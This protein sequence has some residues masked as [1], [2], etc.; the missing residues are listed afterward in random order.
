M[1]QGNLFAAQPRPASL[2]GGLDS[3]AE[4]R[5]RIDELAQRVE[6]YRASYYAGN[7]EISDAAYDALEDELRALDPT[8]PVL[9]RVGSSALVTEWEKARH[10]IPMGSLNKVVNEDELRAWVAR[11]EELLGKEPHAP[12]ASDLFVAEKLDG[13]SIEV[14]YKDGKLVDAITRGDGEWGERITA[15]VAR[16][17]GVPARIRE[18]GHLSVRGEIIL[19]LS[20]M[21]AHFPGVTSPRNMAAGLS[22]RFDGQ[23]AERC[24]VMFYDVAEHAEIPTCRRRFEWLREL[25]FATPR[26]AH[27]TLDDVIDLYRKYGSELRG[28]LDYEIDGLVVYV[29]SLNL[30]T[31]LG[32]LNR[33]PRGA[34]AFKFASPAKVSKVVA[35]QWD[36]GPSGRVTPVAIVEPVELAGAVVQRASLHNAANVRTLGLGVGDEVLVSRR[37]DVIPYVEEVVEKHGPAAQPPTTCGVCSGALVTEGEYILCRNASCRAL[38]E[39]RIHNWIDAIGALEW[40]DKLIEQLVAA[41]H[42]REP[43]DLYKLKVK[44]IADLE[45]R[46]EKIA[47]KCLDQIQS[48][49]PLTLP[50][51]LTAL[52]I[53]GFALQTARLLVSAGH[54]TLDKVRAAK[55]AELAAIPGL[56]AIKAANITRGLAARKDEIDR[57][58]AGGIQPVTTAAEGP[59]GGLTFCFTGS[60]TRPRGELTQLVESNGG[61]VLGSVTKELN[62]LIIADTSSTSS[63]AEK[64]RKYGTKL[65][66]EEQLDQL[67]EERRAA[68]AS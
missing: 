51:F 25:G 64:A 47:K 30:Q 53:E 32:D 1:K 33:R 60:G 61:R 24:T 42:L 23:G 5:A 56:G 8:H 17:K 36:T 13:I 29:D 35:I 27:G 58:I 57:L 18:R 2:Q 63:K 3:N 67:I 10:E 49:L 26:S 43:L 66:T 28:A 44:D 48:R 16:M 55:E 62:Y 37:N 59:L 22:K 11:C 4:Q 41:G 38:I 21:K 6:R 40:G 7:T 19:R 15:N 20:D 52:G 34:V 50:V 46:G 54:D 9:A 31:V 12:V 68:G 65:I 14:L 39:G 45:R